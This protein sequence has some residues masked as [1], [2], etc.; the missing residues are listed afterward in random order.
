MDS[1]G[2]GAFESLIQF[3]AKFP[4][5][6]RDTLSKLDTPVFYFWKCE[7]N[8][9]MLL[10]SKMFL[11]WYF[12]RGQRNANLTYRESPIHNCSF[13]SW[14]LRQKFQ[15]SCARTSCQDVQ[16]SQF[17]VQNSSRFRL[18]VYFRFKSFRDF[19]FR[20]I[21]KGSINTFSRSE[22]WRSFSYLTLVLRRIS[23]L[24][25]FRLK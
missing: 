20:R 25:V 7:F 16:F 11:P 12:L 15:F 4:N 1:Y 19:V 6:H 9:I 22:A 13:S 2:A 21:G 10:T 3:L 18:N 24:V 5:R 17:H 14:D 23:Y 8:L